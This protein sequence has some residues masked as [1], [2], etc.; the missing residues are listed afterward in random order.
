MAATWNEFISHVHI[1]LRVEWVE[2]PASTNRHLGGCAED[3]VSETPTFLV[4]ILLFTSTKTDGLM[5]VVSKGLL[6]SWLIPANHHRLSVVS[7][8]SR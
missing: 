8:R 2:T 4:S 6:F 5:R 3:T 7:V 1:Y